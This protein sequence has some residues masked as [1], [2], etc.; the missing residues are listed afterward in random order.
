MRFRNV[1]YTNP[2]EKRSNDYKCIAELKHNKNDLYVY[3]C[4][5]VYE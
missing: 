2:R 1:A 3:V 4:V 5:C